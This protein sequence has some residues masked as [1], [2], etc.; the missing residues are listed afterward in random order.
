MLLCHLAPHLQWFQ[1]SQT[2][3]CPLWSTCA[4]STLTDI[5]RCFAL[6]FAQLR[7]AVQAVKN[8]A[9]SC[10]VTVQLNFKP[11]WVLG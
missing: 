6:T 10:S 4:Q 9:V 5:H 1:L 3:G 11:M 2:S 8:Q 7:T